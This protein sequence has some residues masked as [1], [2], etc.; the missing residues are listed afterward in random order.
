MIK[1][2]PMSKR[3]RGVS[4]LFFALFDTRVTVEIKFIFVIFKTCSRSEYE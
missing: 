3:K 1:M 2:V 4:F